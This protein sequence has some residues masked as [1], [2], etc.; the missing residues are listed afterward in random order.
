MGERFRKIFGW[1]IAFFLAFAM[2]NAYAQEECNN[3]TDD[4]GDGLVDCNDSDCQYASN[5]ERGCNCND[6]SDNDGDGLTDISDADCASFYGLTFV[7]ETTDC[8]LVPPDSIN[9][10]DYIDD[11]PAKTSQN[12]V[13]TQSKMAIGDLNG[14]G[15]PEVVATSKWNAKVRVIS[16][17]DNYYC[18]T[19]KITERG[20]VVDEYGT[21]GT[22]DGKIFP[23][24]NKYVY[25]LETAI[26]DIEG[27]GQGEVFAIASER[28]T[29]NDPPGNYFMVGLT[30]NVNTC[31]LELI[32]GWGGKA[33]NLGPCRPGIFGLTD[34]DGDGLVEFY[35]KDR[36]YAAESG[37]LLADGDIGRDCETEVN[38]APVA[39]DIISGGNQ[40]LVCGD[41]IYSVPSL[42][43]RNPGS[44]VALTVTHS[45]NDLGFMQ[46][47]PKV[48]NDPVEYGI[49]NYSST[50]VADMNGDGN[51]DVVLSGADANDSTAVFFWDV[52]AGHVSYFIPHDPDNAGGWPWGTSRPNLG[53]ADGDGELDIVIIAGNQ[54]FALTI[55]GANEI[56]ELWATP[57]TINDSR[58]GIVAVTIYD[59]DNDGK[60]E[61]VYRDSQQLV[62]VDGET[63]QNIQWATACQSHTMTEGPIIADVDGDGGTDICVPCYTSKNSFDI[64]Q[65]IQQQALGGL[66]I[67][68]S[69][70]NLWLPTRAVW[71]QSGY[72]VVNINDDL[73]IPFPQFDQTMIFGTE[74]CFDGQAGPV[75]PMNVFL[76]QVPT[77]GPD[78]CPQFP[79]PDIA[80]VGDDPN[81][82]PGDSAYVD[83]SDPSYFPAVDVIPPVCGDL[84]IKVKFNIINNGAL[85]INSIVPVSFFD[86]DPTLDPQPDPPASLLFQYDLN[87][88]NFQVGD[89]LTDSLSFNST[90]KAFRLYVV[91]NDDGSSLPITISGNEL[92][93]CRITNNI[94]Y[95]DITP[96]PFDVYTQKIRDDTRCYDS[97][98][99][100]GELK[101][102][103]IQQGDTVTDYSKFAFAWYDGPD[104]T[105]YIPAPQ[106]DL[107][108]ITGLDSGYYTLV[109]TNTEKGCASLPIVDTLLREG[110][111]VDAQVNVIQEQTICDP[112]DGILEVEITSGSANYTYEW[113]DRFGAP[114]GITGSQAQNLSAA[115]YVVRITPDDGCSSITRRGT[116]TPPTIP[117][118]TPT[119]I[120]HVEDCNNTDSGKITATAYRSGV[121]QDSTKFSF[122]WYEWDTIADDYGSTLAALHGSGPTRYGLPIGEYAVIVK[123]DSTGCESTSQARVIVEDSTLFP[124][125]VISELAPQTSC[126]PLQPNG[127]LI[128]DVY[129]SLGNLQAPA[130]FTFE[131]Y[132]GDNTLPANLMTSVSGT[133]GQI[134]DSV[135][136][137]GLPYT[138]KAINQNNCATVLMDTSLTES[139]IYP[140]VTVTAVDNSICDSTIA[141]AGAY[142]G[143]VQ[144]TISY[145]SVVLADYTGY[146]IDWYRGEIADPDSVITTTNA[147]GDILERLDEGRYT[148]VVTKD[149]ETCSS[150]PVFGQVFD[151]LSYPVIL[152]TE[153][154]AT[155]C[156]P[157]FANGELTANVDVGGV[158]TISGY[159]FSWFEDL[160]TGPTGTPV[161]NISGTSNETALQLQPD[162]LYS[163]KVI[164]EN[165][166]CENTLA[167]TMT[168]ASEKPVITL[169]KQDNSIC[170]TTLTTVNQF[171]GLIGASVT[172]KGAGVADFTDYTFTWHDGNT[173]A[174]PVL[175][176][177]NANGDSIY[178]LPGGFYTSQV[179]NTALGCIADPVTIEIKDTLILPTIE[180]VTITPATNCNGPDNGAIESAVD[181]GGGTL[182]T[183]NYNFDWYEGT[184]AGTFLYTNPIASGL[185]GLQ[186]YTVE[187]T[188]TLTG[189]IN[190]RA[191]ILPDDSENPV[192]NLAQTPN[193][194]CDPVVATA[195]Y[196]GGVS[197]DL[198]YDGVLQADYT[199]Y[200][201]KL[202]EGNNDTTAVNLIETK[203]AAAPVFVQLDSGYYTVRAYETA[204]GCYSDPITI[205]VQDN[206]ILPVIQLDE[207]T[208]TNCDPALPN[209][210]AT[211]TV[212]GSTANYI[213]KWVTGT[214]VT[215]P[216]RADV[217]GTANN[218][219]L[220]MSPD[221][222]YTVKVTTDTTGCYETK[223]IIVSDSSKVPIVT[224]GQ[225][226]NTV[227]DPALTNPAVIYNGEVTGTVAY[228]AI[229]P[230]DLTGVTLALYDGTTTTV[231]NG[232]SPLTQNLQ[233]FI[234]E[235]LDS[236][237][238]TVTALID[239]IGCESAPVSI[240]VA[241][242]TTVPSITIN[243]VAS[244][245]C[246]PA[247][248]NGWATVLSDGSDALYTFKWVAGVDT[249][250]ASISTA[251]LASSLTGGNTYTTIVRTDSSGCTNTEPVIILDEKELPIVTLGQ[252]P[253]SVCD[254]ALTNPAVVYNGEVTGTIAYD[255][256]NPAD[257]TDVTLILYN[258]TTTTVVNGVSPLTQN[259][260]S[261]VYEQLDSGFYTV[262]AEI[263]S[264]GCVSDPV[265]I[266]VQSA[267]QLPNITIV[268]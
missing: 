151:T 220:K 1:I 233:N 102:I 217:T 88:V 193:T 20:D 196:N 197:T 185:A 228:R 114:L 61:I 252:K 21:T 19:S 7:G 103:I 173:T 240:K 133:N 190:T 141:T 255:V 32:D 91:L 123:N 15:L 55:N 27:D 250:A 205:R 224:L 266:E 53:D 67:F 218:I 207:I 244:T 74:P 259:L 130:N 54:L 265:N 260:Q 110:S 39:V 182:T 118:V 46:F 161:A 135:H 115:E 5:V 64:D 179:E 129:D 150:T 117:T 188:N 40:E 45:M 225:A 38:G 140:Q 139:L 136:A 142:N 223:A 211:A 34:F 58:S 10:F 261:F 181:I 68:Y 159:T 6:G 107:D 109:V 98:P 227:C 93:E 247:L 226:P 60:P 167:H 242:S 81:A 194:I 202:F 171:N 72:F 229:N 214:D 87:M 50:S 219:S 144:A 155:N 8:S 69:E 79:A 83:P 166:G 26:A 89:T 268:E 31:E 108:V 101:A 199:N 176:S 96:D 231:V 3:G 120:Q 147:A 62:I 66:N 113:F 121:A 76:N 246:D 105:T 51:L 52:T 57:R 237:F 241:D 245:N 127:R 71:N 90:G 126:D 14:D 212:S 41:L 94:Y 132:E 235:Q 84:E 186:E 131:W 198:F 258:G 232:A 63:G 172:D 116:L 134:A 154:P 122:Y 4:D 28:Q 59:F 78:G 174:D 152:V 203:V 264:L 189:C 12:T 257:L 215:D 209:G 183:N 156:D 153:I 137:Q 11:L 210:Q 125:V 158:P 9:V 249:S 44:P 234:Y 24:G 112:P 85:T 204:L 104:T 75:R 213:F 238:Y 148:I 36:I 77:L 165:T 29:P 195:N 248:A 178:Y 192:I 222:T 262:T 13:D 33:V 200:T 119:V 221:T 124:V 254:P 191:M 25:E 22:P 65:G 37:A 187:V 23:S 208:A 48:L 100:N 143:S 180:W 106:G 239:S 95:F 164:Q 157:A 56:E 163:V 2:V 18:S 145:D 73:T 177:T 175:T 243:Q 86:G 149:N 263:D 253:N 201:F 111:Q 92:N 30:F 47:S 43:N 184:T 256:I 216:E 99:A 170:D 16:S 146:T 267:S 82:Q 97:I 35:L 70:E 251:S 160:D 230:A 128:A 138:V 169:T 49:T 80:F 206:F 42:S 162:S 168:N 236:G 17:G